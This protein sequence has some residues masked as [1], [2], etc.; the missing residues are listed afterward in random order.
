MGFLLVPLVAETDAH[1]PVAVS[2]AGHRRTGDM[3]SC[4][5][6]LSPFCPCLPW[7]CFVLA[8]SSSSGANPGA[9]LSMDGQVAAHVSKPES[10]LIPPRKHSQSLA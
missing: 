4:P 7:A 6:V 1:G 8:P 2:L 9:R 3:V 10:E 5:C